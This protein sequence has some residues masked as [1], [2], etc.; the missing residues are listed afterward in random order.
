MALLSR[1]VLSGA[2]GKNRATIASFLGITT[3]PF[4]V[5]GVIVAWLPLPVAAEPWTTYRGNPQRTG[6]TDGVAV[7]DSPRVVWVHKAQEHFLASPVPVA[8][9]LYVAGLGGFNVPS[10]LCLNVESN[11]PQRVAWVKTAPY[12]KLPTVSSPAV[13]AGRLFF[14]DGMHQTDG[15]IFHCLR[16][17]TGLPVWQL[18]APGKLVHLEGAPTVAD[19]RAI[20]GGGSAGVLCVEAGRVQLD[21]RDYDLEAVQKVLDQK[22][23]ELQA[24]YEADK[25]KDPDFAIP[26][27]EDQLPKPTPRRLWQ[28]GQGKWHVDAPVAVVGSRVLVASSFLDK[29][30]LGDRA[31]YCLDAASGT[32]QW[33][34]PLKLNP[35]GGPSLLGEVVVVAGSSIGYDPKALNGARGDIAAY[36]LATGKERW[37]KEVPGG[38]VGGA[39]LAAGLAVVTATD[40]KVRAFDLATG[41]RRWLYDAKAPLFAPPAVA[42][43]TVIVGDLKGVVHALTLSDGQA[44]WTL[45]L[46]ADPAVRAPGMIFAGPVASNGKLFV[47]TCNHEGPYAGKPTVVVCLGTR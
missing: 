28:Q 18:P 5:V 25:K 42:G 8:Q 44:R 47:V 20:I 17:D 7:P 37:R 22:W 15:A 43:D 9:R 30:Q 24:K 29:E 26:P 27:N 40:G 32:V 6:C 38:I 14:G 3:K 21:G 1:G 19:G 31:L 34:T 41:E 35:W 33:R 12:L 39:A 10:L 16:A 46:G 36:E 23:R 4:L 45:N 13:S 2:S 11:A